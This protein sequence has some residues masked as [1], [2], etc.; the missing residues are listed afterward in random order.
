ME[1]VNL[2]EMWPEV[3]DELIARVVP[4][5]RWTS[6]A[7]PFNRRQRQRVASSSSVILHL[8]SGPDQSWW[9]KRLD[10]NSRVVLC[11]DKSADS[12]QDLLSDQLTSFLAEVC[13]RGVVDVILRGPPCRT[14]SK[15]GDTAVV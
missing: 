9:K 1:V 13:E 5:G 3:P 7:A 6:D 10:S 11:I 12:N 4:T 15:A 2:R 8:F 14:V